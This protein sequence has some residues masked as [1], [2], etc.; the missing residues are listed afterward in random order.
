MREISA[1]L[2]AAEVTRSVRDARIGD[3]E[4]PEGAYIGF[5]DGELIA[6]EETSRRP[7]SCSPRKIWTA[8]PTS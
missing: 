6:V 5:L 7:R 8:A 1:R 2:R 3:R 4:V